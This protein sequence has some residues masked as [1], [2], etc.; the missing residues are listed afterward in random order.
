MSASEFVEAVTRATSKLQQI[1]AVGHPP[2]TPA[3]VTQLGEVFDRD[4]PRFGS[5]ALSAKIS[6]VGG[7]YWERV[8]ILRL[9]SA[10]P[11]PAQTAYAAWLSSGPVVLSQHPAALAAVN[12]EEHSARASDPDLSVAFASI[13]GVWTGASL[14]L[15]IRLHNVD[16]IPFRH[17]TDNDRAS[18]AEIRR[19]F[20]AQIVPPAVERLADGVRV[21]I[22]IVSE[23]HLRRRVSEVRGGAL[24]VTEEVLAQVPTFPGKMWAMKNNR[25]VPV[26]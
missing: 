5:R 17:A 10:S 19:T 22:W 20:G 12:A 2:L 6:D 26:G 4:L 9:D 8:R 18:E 11:F 23:A 25:F 7:V 14:M 16:D 13:A 15:E 3:Q 1:Q 24:A 21:T